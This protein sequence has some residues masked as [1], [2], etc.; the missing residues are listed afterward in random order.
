MSFITINFHE[1]LLRGFRG[2]A[3]TRKTGLTD[4]LTDWLTDR[5]KTLYPSQLVAW[6]IK[7]FFTKRL[8]WDIV[9]KLPKNKIKNQESSQLIF[10]SC[11]KFVLP[12]NI[13]FN[14][15]KLLRIFIKVIFLVNE[16]YLTFYLCYLSRYYFE[17][18]TY[19]K[20]N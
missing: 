18:Q 5:S 2:V 6:G 9:D 16:I 3:L 7:R 20:V 11:R 10:Q 8:R 15:I 1:I 4:W 12:S 19:F 17:Y 14:L 13:V